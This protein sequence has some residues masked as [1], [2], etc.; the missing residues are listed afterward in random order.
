L[1]AEGLG[2]R[3]SSLGVEA[4]YP[5]MRRQ[6][7]RANKP[8]LFARLPVSSPRVKICNMHR[9]VSVH[10]RAG[11]ACVHCD[12]SRLTADAAAEVPCTLE[13]RERECVLSI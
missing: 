8:V 11:P 2:F 6:E 4:L 13:V 1:R 9:S 3:V 10:A 5:L 7:S 12:F